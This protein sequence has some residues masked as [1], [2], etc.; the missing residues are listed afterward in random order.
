MYLKIKPNK[1]KAGK[2]SQN[3]LAADV[4][5]NEPYSRH[6]FNSV[7]PLTLEQLPCCFRSRK[8]IVFSAHLHE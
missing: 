5:N 8:L 4:H 3:L 7:E 2:T 1:F 6:Y